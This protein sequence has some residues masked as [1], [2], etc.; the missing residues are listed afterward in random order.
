MNMDEKTF[1]KNF[2]IIIL[3]PVNKT[4]THTLPLTS[5]YSL[6]C[7]HRFL[8]VVLAVTAFISESYNTE[9]GS[10]YEPKRKFKFFKVF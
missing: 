2:C 6:A 3:K 4:H 9:K 10:L 5:A 8:S 1:K 7:E